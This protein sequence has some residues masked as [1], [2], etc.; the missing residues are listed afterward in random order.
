VN[1]PGPENLPEFKTCVK[2]KSNIKFRK[3]RW[4]C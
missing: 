1:L 2:E 4:F 3:N